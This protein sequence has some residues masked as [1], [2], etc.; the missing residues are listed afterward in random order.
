[1]SAANEGRNSPDPDHQSDAQIGSI[2]D[3]NLEASDQSHDDKS[4]ASD[5]DGLSTLSSNPKGAID[6]AATK[7]TSKA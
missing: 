6:D 3:P 2:A 1:M 7:S 4:K 5:V